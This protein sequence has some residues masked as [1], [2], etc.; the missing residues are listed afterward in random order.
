MDNAIEI[1]RQIDFFQNF[2]RSEI[3][4]IIDC[5]AWVHS[6]RGERI[7]TEGETDLFLYVLI[8]G[9]VNVVKNGK[10]LA[11]IKAGDSFGEIAALAG[12]P[13]TAH[14]ITKEECYCLRFDPFQINQM[15]VKLQLKFVKKIL[16][17]MASRLVT[18][19]RRFAI[20]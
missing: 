18:L 19:D 7:I 14:V 16:Y 10:V 15:E 4:S 1:L 17:T 5:G 13:R 2:S 9:Q 6:S 11:V 12:S 8:K 3:D 20:L